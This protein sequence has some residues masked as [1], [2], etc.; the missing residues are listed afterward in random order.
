MGERPM[1]AWLARV[2]GGPRPGQPALLVG[3]AGVGKSAILVHVGLE[4][5]RGEGRV[6]HVT[7][8]ETVGQVR[9]FYDDA[10]RGLGVLPSESVSLERRRMILSYVDRA[11]DPVHLESQAR[12]LRDIAAF[13]ADVLLLDGLTAQAWLAHGEA[14][15]HLSQTLGL[16]LWVTVASEG[17]VI[18]SGGT[19]R[20]VVRVLDSAEGGLRL[21]VDGHE[22]TLPFRLDATAQQV[23]PT[24]VAVPSVAKQRLRPAD[25]TLFAGGAPGAEAAF[26]EAAAACGCPEVHFTFEGHV[27]ARVV[28]QR[29]LTPAELEV[30]DVSIVYVSRRLNRQYN[31]TGLIRRVLQTLWHMV[32]RSEQVFVVGQIQEDGTVVGGTGWAVELAR[33]MWSKDLWVFDQGREGWFRWSGQAWQP[34]SPQITATTVCGT[35]TRE[36]T[37]AGRAA[38]AALFADSFAERSG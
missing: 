8:R 20:V 32:S 17:G 38:I 35:G 23:V 11:F 6:L 21:A 2:D 22:E 19:A 24:D 9:A 13:E 34:G 16:S 3:D 14:L 7:L 18:R 4:A 10:G 15:G 5:L 30:G 37:S 27:Q 29:V 25:V 12:M 36:L 31:E 1:Q 33:M 28:G 26:G